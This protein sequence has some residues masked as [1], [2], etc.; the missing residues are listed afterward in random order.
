MR[1]ILIIT[2]V[3]FLLIMSTASAYTLKS[4]KENTTSSGEATI[5]GSVKAAITCVPDPLSGAI[6]T[7]TNMNPLKFQKYTAVTNSSGEFE[8]KVEPGTYKISAERENYRPIMP[9]IPII[10]N[11]DDG[12]TCEC[13]FMMT[14]AR[15]KDL[16]FKITNIDLLKEIL[17]I[18]KFKIS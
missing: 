12:E 4:K 14:N 8:I 13:E 18:V 16:A 6:V 3:I 7:A 11:L 9:R 10:T 1:K 2:I 5:R 17:S 15:S